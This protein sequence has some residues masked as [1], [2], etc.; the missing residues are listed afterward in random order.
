MQYWALTKGQVTGWG[1]LTGEGDGGQV[2]GSNVYLRRGVMVGRR[3][4]AIEQHFY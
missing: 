2:T 1:R 4:I 3:T